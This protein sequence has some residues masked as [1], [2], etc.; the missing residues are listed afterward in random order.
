MAQLSLATR[1][2]KQKRQ[3][4]IMAWWNQVITIV[5]WFVISLYMLVIEYEMERPCIRYSTSKIDRFL[6]LHRYVFESDTM[7][8]SQI[9]M[10]RKCFV[11]LCNM[12]ET[13]G[14]LKASRNMDIDEQVAIFLHIIAHNVKNR[15]MIC[16]FYRS[17]ETISRHFSRVWRIFEQSFVKLEKYVCS[18]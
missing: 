6:I 13:L 1:K 18:P 14:G 3:T 15:V 4:M 10:T 16:R 12:L 11:K 2:R 17:G 7:S 9:R 8:I 5:V